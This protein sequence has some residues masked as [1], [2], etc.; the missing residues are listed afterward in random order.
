MTGP[1]PG[2]GPAPAC[3]QRRIDSS[4]TRSSWATCPQ[5]NDL[6]KVPSVD[7]A[8]TPWPN[9]SVVAA[10]RIASASSMQSPPARAE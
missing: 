10:T 6:K 5:E 8:R 9:T 2:P 3:Q 4:N 7:G 1:T